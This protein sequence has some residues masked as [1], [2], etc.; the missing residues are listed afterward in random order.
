MTV[1]V[2]GLKVPS[3]DENENGYA[4]VLP[5]RRVGAYSYVI[6]LHPIRKGP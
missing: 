3:P 4:K 5:Y 6:R 1:T 2:G